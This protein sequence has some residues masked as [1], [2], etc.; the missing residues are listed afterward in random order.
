MLSNTLTATP[1]T[2]LNPHFTLLEE[3][4]SVD[5]PGLVEKYEVFIPQALAQRLISAKSNFRC[6]KDLPSSLLL[7]TEQLLHVFTVYASCIEFPN[8]VLKYR[9]VEQA[10]MQPPALAEREE[11]MMALNTHLNEL[12]RD[13]RKRE[14]NEAIAQEHSRRPEAQAYLAERQESCLATPHGQATTY[15][16]KVPL[17]ALISIPK[18]ALACPMPSAPV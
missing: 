2:R 5:I 17:V 14:D 1:S 8:D 11:M 6:F 18:K 9:P 16:L 4:Q 13:N 10:L 7:T 3:E 12:A 15:R